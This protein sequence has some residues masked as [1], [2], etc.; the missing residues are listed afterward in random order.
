VFIKQQG[1]VCSCAQIDGDRAKLLTADG[2]TIDT[3]FVDRRSTTS[4][5]HGKTLVSKDADT[6]LITV[7]SFV[8]IVKQVLSEILTNYAVAFLGFFKGV[9]GQF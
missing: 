6:R 9:V 3:M 2:N 7:Q 1:V 8:L 4:Q 5:Q